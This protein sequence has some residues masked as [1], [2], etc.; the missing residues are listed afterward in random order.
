MLTIIHALLDAAHVHGRVIY[1]LV[2]KKLEYST[3]FSRKVA[4]SQVHTHPQH[5]VR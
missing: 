3:V 1:A 5:V 4:P 2:H